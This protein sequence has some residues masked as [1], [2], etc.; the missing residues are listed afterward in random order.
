[1]RVIWIRHGETLWN[2]EFRLQGTSDVALSEVGLTQAESLATRLRAIPTQ[3][4][5]S[6]LQRTQAFA[7]PLAN[8]HEVTVQLLADLREMSFGRWEGLRYADMDHQMQKAYEAWY[9][10][11]V[12]I[13]PP[14][15]ESLTCLQGRVQTA[16]DYIALHSGSE[17]TVVAVTH[18]GIIRAAVTL[19]MQMPLATVSRIHID[20]A[21]ATILDFYNGSW[22]LVKLNDTSHL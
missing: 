2:K 11:P 3:I 19:A 1:M 9:A 5:V 15:G 4:Y 12:A 13:Y 22:S 10:D 6:P 8:R 20:T 14:G 18:G 16:M 17:E 7:A 21:S